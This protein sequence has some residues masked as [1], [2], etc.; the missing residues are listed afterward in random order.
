MERGRTTFDYQHPKGGGIVGLHFV[1]LYVI[2]HVNC[3]RKWNKE[4][5]VGII[6]NIHRRQQKTEEKFEDSALIHECMLFSQQGKFL[7]V[8]VHLAK[9]RSTYT[10]I[11]NSK[12]VEKA[13]QLP[14]SRKTSLVR[15]SAEL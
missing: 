15:F 3:K 8:K 13:L 9:I 7:L 4:I 6:N 1:Y 2:F 14:K 11:Q 5:T 12:A 10:W